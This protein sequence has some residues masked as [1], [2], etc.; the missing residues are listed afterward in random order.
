MAT[1]DPTY[2]YWDVLS[3][4]APG[5]VATRDVIDAIAARY[6]AN[7]YTPL[8]QD[9]VIAITGPLPPVPTKLPRFYDNDP[10]PFDG[11]AQYGG[12]Q[13]ALTGGV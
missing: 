1:P 7:G 4:Y 3:L 6:A 2:D 13:I 5:V 8:T 10:D 12:P 11:W 9:Q